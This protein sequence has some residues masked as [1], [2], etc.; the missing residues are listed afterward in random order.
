M[1]SQEALQDW[2]GLALRVEEEVRR[3]IVGQDDTLRLINVA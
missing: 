3:A 1:L 2:R